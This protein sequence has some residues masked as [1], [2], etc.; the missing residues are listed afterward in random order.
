MPPA[1][2]RALSQ[3]SLRLAELPLCTLSIVLPQI[4]I[5]RANLWDTCVAE[6]HMGSKDCRDIWEF[7]EVRLRFSKSPAP[8]A[9]LYSSLRC[10][11]AQP[12]SRVS[13]NRNLYRH[14]FP[15]S[16][17]KAGMPTF[18]DMPGPLCRFSSYQKLYCT[19]AFTLCS[20]LFLATSKLYAP[21]SVQRS[22]ML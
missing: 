14:K 2:V 19:P 11:A 17:S 6:D 12:R 13:V 9:R 16:G 21:R 3:A 15:L 10:P 20:L 7:G 18:A 8:P 1:L 5:Y 22:V 4:P